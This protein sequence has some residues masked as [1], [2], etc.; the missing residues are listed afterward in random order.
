M[1]FQATADN[2]APISGATIN[3]H[4]CESATPPSNNA[5]PMLRAG[6]TDVPVMGMQAMWMSTSDKP[7][8]NPAKLPAPF[9]LSVLPSTTSTDIKVKA[10]S[11]INACASCRP[12]SCCFRWL[13]FH[14]GSL[15]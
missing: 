15:C 3:S 7:M 6:L 5:G 9:L 10:A 8:A 2:A 14:R 1:A 12:C 13:S 11:A 4:N